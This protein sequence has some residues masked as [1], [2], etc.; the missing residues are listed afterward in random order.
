MNQDEI[1]RETAILIAIGKLYSE[2]ATML[3]KEYKQRQKQVFNQSVQAIDSFVNH[4]EKL[5]MTD[6]VKLIEGIVDEFHNVFNELRKWTYKQWLK[7]PST[8]RKLKILFADLK[9]FN[10]GQLKLF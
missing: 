1:A 4:V 3:T 6:E 5:M 2:Q 9:E 7:K 8:K 10:S